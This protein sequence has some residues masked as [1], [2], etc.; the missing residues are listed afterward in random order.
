ML[1]RQRI[2]GLMMVLLLSAV[3][4][5]AALSSPSIGEMTTEAAGPIGAGAGLTTL[6]QGQILAPSS[7]NLLDTTPSKPEFAARSNLSL[8]LGGN[9]AFHSDR[10]GGLDVYAQNSDGSEEAVPLVASSGQDV[11]P[12]WSPDGTQLLFA[13][14]R[15]GD[16]DIYLRNAAGEEIN[17]TR[18]TAADAHPAWSPTGERIIFTS[19]RGGTFFQIFTMNLDGGD[20][21]Q[22]GVVE[23]NNAVHPRYSP[24][25]SRIAY[26][27]ASV[28]E[29]L[30]QWNWDVWV[31]EADG[32]NQRRV[33]NRLCADLYPNWSPDGSEIVYTSCDNCIDFDLYSVNPDTGTERQITSRLWENEWGAVFAPAGDYFA[34]NSDHDGNTEIYV[35][36]AAGQTAFNLTQ[37]SASDLVGSWADQAIPETYSISGRVHNDA[38]KPIPAITI[39]DDKGHTTLTGMQGDYTLSGLAGGKY[40]V[41]PSKLGYSFVPETLTVNVPPSATGQN[42]AGTAITTAITQPI[43]LV[44]G[45]QVKGDWQPAEVPTPWKENVT[46]TFGEMPKWLTEAGYDVWIAHL[47]TGIFGTPVAEENARWLDKQVAYVKRERDVDVILIGHSMG[48][49]VSRACVAQFQDCRENVAA[50]YTLGSP[51]GGS[52]S[53]LFLKTLGLLASRQTSFVTRLF[54]AYHDLLCQISAENMALSFNPNNPN[55]SS[56]EYHFIG[57]DKTPS[58]IGSLVNILD[59]PN[60]GVIG[61]SSAV[62]WYFPTNVG[63]PGSA[64]GRYWTSEIHSAG[65]LLGYPS[66]VEREDGDKT[67]SFLCIDSLLKADNQ[68]V[69]GAQCRQA[70]LRTNQTMG[71]GKI[72][73][74]DVTSSLSGRLESRQTVSRTLPVDTSGQSLFYLSWFTGTFAFTLTQP[75]GQVITPEYAALHSDEV[76]YVAGAGDS[77]ILP[78]A[79]YAFTTTLPGTYTLN[80]SAGEAD[81]NY[82]AFVAMEA[83][84]TFTVTANAYLFQPRTTAVLTGTLRGNSGGIDGAHIEAQLVRADGLTETLKLVGLGGG[85]YKAAYVV[86]DVPGYLQAVITANGDDNGTPFVRQEDKL[87]A[88]APHSARL[89][90]RYRD[91]PRDDDRDG[92]NDTLALDVGVAVTQ[93]GTYTLSADLT[94]DGQTISHAAHYAVLGAGT[95]TVTLH[96]DGWDIRRS[97][98]DGP[99][100][101]S[102]VRLVDLSVGGIPAESADNVWTTDA[103]D[104][105]DFGFDSLYLPLLLR[106]R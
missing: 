104:W 77:S 88:V 7:P 92:F 28:T 16:Y 27:R 83:G 87:L 23:G 14:D 18:D 84:R 32:S 81:S 21:Q 33:T 86:P 40:T 63:I 54:C 98:F 44:H 66:Y 90:G 72:M 82:V 67:E 15:D 78:A 38:G 53:I 94:A 34:F 58:P 11:T 35:A 99:F 91:E 80:I 10:S 41:T 65:R 79:T 31:M 59:G 5:S 19:N 103:Y 26:T 61:A 46:T 29:P 93:V 30:C 3:I 42:F 47:D 13:S 62:G 6:L 70:S 100:T 39:S 105:R 20:V 25:G 52:N 60:D 43:L 36:P 49:L 37:N 55:L 101:F 102:Q 74:T 95:Q 12:V 71:T 76:N 9:I 8:A 85:L 2:L 68:W 96:F 57:G 97:R 45:W 1:T 75:S 17:L 4:L 56:V 69:P 48:G 64:P 106:N 50:I 22:V 89:T 73:L 24:D 51:H